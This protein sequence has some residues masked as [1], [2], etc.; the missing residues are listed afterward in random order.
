MP[1][2]TR[3]R[4]NPPPLP[5]KSRVRLAGETKIKERKKEEQKEKKKE[6]EKVGK[7]ATVIRIASSRDDRSR[8]WLLPVSI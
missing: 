5:P 7:R 2:A 1:R 8:A 3:K 4:S 6:N